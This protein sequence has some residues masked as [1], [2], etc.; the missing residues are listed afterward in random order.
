MRILINILAVALTTGAVLLAAD[1][2]RA[3]G[4]RFASPTAFRARWGFPSTPSSTSP[5]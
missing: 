4:L 1:V 2:P 5:R 3:V